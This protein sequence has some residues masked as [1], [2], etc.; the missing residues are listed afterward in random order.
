MTITRIHINFSDGTQFDID[1]LMVDS[2][3]R[4]D[5]NAVVA[6]YQPNLDVSKLEMSVSGS[7]VNLHPAAVFGA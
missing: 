1:N 4:E 6:E 7:V 2:T 5:I 3:D